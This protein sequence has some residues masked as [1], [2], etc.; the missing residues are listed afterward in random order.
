M[1]PVKKGENYY[2][3]HY[4][5]RFF[6]HFISQS[7]SREKG[8]KIREQYDEGIIDKG[9]GGGG[10]GRPQ[11]LVQPSR[12]QCQQGACITPTTKT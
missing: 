8:E 7:P 6:S 2:I 1:S 11:P 10:E 12:S 4:D 9:K 3:T 5:I